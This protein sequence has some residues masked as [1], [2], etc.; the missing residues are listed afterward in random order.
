MICTT[1]KSVLSTHVSH[2]MLI[3]YM[4]ETWNIEAIFLQYYEF[5]FF[6]IKN[7]DVD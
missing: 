6:R 3:R 2:V 4:F 7:A 5:T 1:A